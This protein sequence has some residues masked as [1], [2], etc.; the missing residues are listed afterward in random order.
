MD[1]FVLYL[2]NFAMID[3]K[4]NLL[5]STLETAPPS[6][7]KKEK[8]AVVQE[9]V[10]TP[11]ISWALDFLERIP[12]R[13]GQRILD[14][15]CRDGRVTAEIA[16]RF[17]SCDILALDNEPTAVEK[18]ESTL[19][20]YAPRVEVMAVDARELWFAGVFDVVLSFSCLHWIEDKAAVMVG[21]QNA[22]KPGGLAYIQFFAD[23]GRD[24]FDSCIYELAK[25]A[26]WQPFFAS[27]APEDPTLYE[28]NPQTMA[29]IIEASG[30]Q[31]IQAEFVRHKVVFADRHAM[32]NWIATWCQHL[33]C[34]PEE[35]HE[36]FL[37]DAVD[38]YVKQ[39]GGDKKGPVNHY[40]YVLEL[41]LKKR[42]R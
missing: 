40:D 19:A 12:L 4:E 42:Q 17:P 28:V 26:K 41:K 9:I 13:D 36:A 10:D 32:A 33:K 8:G 14:V 39:H 35:K 1:I 2:D 25:Q 11:V 7:S 6:S 3:F 30:F 21:M 37:S 5:M 20:K 18:A 27:K 38:T 23:H 16:R 34:L 22:L 29:S 24:R 15:G 31:T